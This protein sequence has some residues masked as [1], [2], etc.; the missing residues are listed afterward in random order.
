VASSVASLKNATPDRR[1]DSAARL[2][3]LTRR[4]AAADEKFHSALGPG[5]GDLRTHRFMRELREAAAQEFGADFAEQRIC[6][7]TSLAVDYYFPAEETVVEI[8]LGLP[9]P[10]S[11]FEKDVLKAIMA[12]EQGNRVRRRVFISRPGGAKKCSQ[13]GRSAVIRWALAKHHLVVEVLELE[14]KPRARKRRRRT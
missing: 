8:A 11:E 1:E 13:P 2:L 12:Q 14:G 10:G 5:P 6:G 3:V 4:L 7:A 9:N